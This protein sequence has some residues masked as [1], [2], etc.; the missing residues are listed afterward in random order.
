[1]SAKR[2]AKLRT[3]F[4]MTRRSTRNKLMHQAGEMLE[5]LTLSEVLLDGLIKSVSK[6]AVRELKKA[7]GNASKI[8]ALADEQSDYINDHLPIIMAYLDVIIKGVERF[9]EGL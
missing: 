3:K 6:D 7:Q 8:A 2:P 5:R 9:E 1:M 4:S